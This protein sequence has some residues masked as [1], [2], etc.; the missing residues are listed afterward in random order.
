MTM[1]NITESQILELILSK[2]K[3]NDFQILEVETGAFEDNQGEQKRYAR[4]VVC[5]KEEWKLLDSVGLVERAEKI[6]FPVVQYDGSD[7]TDKVGKSVKASNVEQWFLRKS[8]VDV[9]FGRQETQ[10]VGIAYKMTMQELA[11]L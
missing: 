1:L 3:V 7:L 8:K 2:N 10:I 5:D 4:L 9:G 6:K 11:T